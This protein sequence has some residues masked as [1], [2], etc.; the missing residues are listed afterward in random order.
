MQ[1]K[2]RKFALAVSLA[3][4]STSAVALDTSVPLLCAVTQVQQ[5]IDGRGCDLVLPEEVNAP[6]FLRVDMKKK[7]LRVTKSG[8]PA[9]IRYHQIVR[10]RLVMMGAE[11]GTENQPGG[12]G[13][14]MSIEQDTGRCA[15]SRVVEQASINLFG[16]CTEPFY[17]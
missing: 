14:I 15:G 7:Q 13:W 2:T 6:T 11:D 16:A 3:V 12:G 8:E 4:S 9:A 10:E 1:N 5:C 17:D